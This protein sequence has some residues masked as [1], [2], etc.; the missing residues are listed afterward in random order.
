MIEQ[1]AV[2]QTSTGRVLAVFPPEVTE[3]NVR[4]VEAEAVANVHRQTQVPT[5]DMRVA[6][7]VFHV[8]KI[9]GAP[10][11][12]PKTRPKGMLVI[13]MHR[14]EE[15]ALRQPDGTEVGRVVLVDIRGNK[16]RVGFQFPKEMKVVG[17]HLLRAEQGGTREGQAESA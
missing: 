8:A 12:R 13:S 9:V 1:L 2:V 4:E 14:D 5:A 6:L 3:A 15:T 7:V 10:A 17:P 11:P 16:V